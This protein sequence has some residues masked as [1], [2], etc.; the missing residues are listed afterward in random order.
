MLPKSVPSTEI[1]ITSESSI[2]VHMHNLGIFNKYVI[3][4]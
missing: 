1:L 2:E 4:N 3:L